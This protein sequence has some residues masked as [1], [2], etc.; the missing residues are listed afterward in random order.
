MQVY[1]TPT[2]QKELNRLPNKIALKI[3][4]AI[5][6]LASDPFPPN[7]K[8]LQSQNNTYRI[9]IGNYR[10]IYALDN[11]SKLIYVARIRHRK[12]AYR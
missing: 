3:S 2:A 1:I 11:S 9:R 6:E 10:I 7:F 4:S 12:D 5:V 8:K